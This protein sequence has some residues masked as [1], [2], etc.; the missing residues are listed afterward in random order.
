M[1]AIVDDDLRR[2]PSDPPTSS[3]RSFAFFNRPLLAL[4]DCQFLREF[5]GIDDLLPLRFEVSHS[6]KQAFIFLHTKQIPTLLNNNFCF[7]FFF[8][9][10]LLLAKPV[11][12]A[13]TFNLLLLL[14]R[15]PRVFF[16]TADQE[17]DSGHHF[18]S[19]HIQN[20]LC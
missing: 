7:F 19:A 5:F 3:S 9:L 16:A 12:R 8:L 6:Q 2:S 10:F 18:F 13:F 11:L 17:P 20:L 4:I 15:E 14:S 1:L